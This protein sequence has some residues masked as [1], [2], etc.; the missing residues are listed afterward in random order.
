M[1]SKRCSPI[2][3]NVIALVFVLT[4]ISFVWQACEL[5]CHHA[6]IEK[7]EATLENLR[8]ENRSMESYVSLRLSELNP[9]QLAQSQNFEKIS[10]I[11][12]IEV[13]P[14]SVARR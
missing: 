4:G 10:E 5:N 13:A 1:I 3:F 14:S 9:E 7:N 6:R 11:E 8:M 2:Y 12:Y